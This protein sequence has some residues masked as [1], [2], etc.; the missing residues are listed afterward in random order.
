[1]KATIIVILSTSAGF[2]LGYLTARQLPESLY[3]CCH[4]NVC[5][6]TT[7]SDCTGDL[8]WCDA[9]ETTVLPDGSPAVVCHD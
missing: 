8:Y 7:P 3:V 6:V 5:T 4:D 2:V 9:G 1:M